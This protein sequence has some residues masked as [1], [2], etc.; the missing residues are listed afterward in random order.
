MTRSTHTVT[1]VL[2]Y[3]LNTKSIIIFKYKPTNVD[4]MQYTTYT[5]LSYR[6]DYV[7]TIPITQCSYKGLRATILNVGVKMSNFPAAISDQAAVCSTVCTLVEP[8]GATRIVS[9]NARMTWVVKRPKG[10]TRKF[11]SE[12]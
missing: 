6:N 1:H 8:F 9:R 2:T 11:C 3:T 5:R 4:S 7:N 10:E 12:Q